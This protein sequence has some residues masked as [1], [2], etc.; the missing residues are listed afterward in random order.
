MKKIYM[1]W[2]TEWGN[3][4]IFFS[5]EKDAEK[6]CTLK[7]DKND[8][9]AEVVNHFYYK[10][11]ELF[12]CLGD[13]LLKNKNELKIDLKKAIE[14]L[15]DNLKRI[16]NNSAYFSVDFGDTFY[17]KLNLNEF[18]ILLN[19]INTKKHNGECY[20]AKTIGYETFLGN[21]KQEQRSL[22][23]NDLPKIKE[24]YEQAILNIKS[25]KQRLKEYQKMYVELFDKE[26]EKELQK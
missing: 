1:I 10:E 15:K 4:G 14:G 22:T 21:W 2:E 6:F 9:N 23:K 5:N 20:L 11:M 17:L 7:N 3:T 19:D 8:I 26:E 24:C 16:E 13:C 25:M 12:D 18:E